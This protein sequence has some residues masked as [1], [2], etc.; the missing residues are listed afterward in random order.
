MKYRIFILALLL[1]NTIGIFA[2][3]VYSDSPQR[4]MYYRVCNNSREPNFS[5]PSY[6]HQ[7]LV[8]WQRQAYENLCYQQLDINKEFPLRDVER[9]VYHYSVHDMRCLIENEELPKEDPSNPFAVWCM[10]RPFYAKLLL[11]AKQ[12]EYLRAEIQDP[13]YYPASPT[14]GFST[15]EELLDEIADEEKQFTLDNES[16]RFYLHRYMLQR[17]RILFSLGRYDECVALWENNIIHW[18]KDDLMRTMI[19]DYIAGAYAH[20]GNTERAKQYYFEQGDLWSLADLSKMEG[21]GYVGLIRL[22]YDFDPDCSELIAP[23]LQSELQDLGQYWVDDEQ[24]S[25]QC[26]AYYDL[27]QYII[28]THRSKDMSLWYYTAAYLEDMMGNPHKAAQSIRLA[29]NGTR[30]STPTLGT[31]S[32]SPATDSTLTESIRLMRIYL[33]AKTQFYNAAYEQQLLTDLRWIDSLIKADTARLRKDWDDDYTVWQIRNNYSQSYG[34]QYLCYPYTMLRKTILS[35]VAPRMKKAGKQSLSIALTNYANNMLIGMMEPKQQ[36][37]FSN[38]LFM[39]M[40]TISAAE[41]ERYASRALQ[42]QTALEKFL[43]DGSYIDHDY[44]YDIVGTLYL[45]ERNYKKAM[46]ILSYVPSAYQKRLHTRYYLQRDPFALGIHLDYDNI[47]E[48]KYNF[49]REMYFLDQTFSNPHIDPNRRA[50]AMLSYAIGMRN[51]YFN[52]WAFTQY[53][54]SCDDFT[55]YSYSWKTEERK[56]QIE[57]EYSRLYRTAFALFTDDESAAAAHLRIRSNYTIVTRYPNTAAAEVIRQ[58]CDTYADYH[59]EFHP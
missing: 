50:N 11:I 51:S 54:Q 2:C 57:A 37:C 49:A 17:I 59:P 7:N 8:S 58:H 15:L 4:L 22:V 30:L 53:E 31:R 45:R 27:M 47:E 46:E 3:G 38:D 14:D 16:C 33:D 12:V 10:Q 44:L 41:V 20:T 43:A 39:A 40:D 26:Q 1:N 5:Q 55:E 36:Y 34:H 18:N 13:W 24:S 35:E 32:S 9:V 29:A 6:R 23:A 28:R 42:P 56:E 48:R 25:A 52:A 19:K 21:N